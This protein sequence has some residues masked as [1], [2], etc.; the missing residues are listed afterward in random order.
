MKLYIILKY[1]LDENEMI[2]RDNE[3]ISI[4]SDIY[5][6]FFYYKKEYRLIGDSYNKYYIKIY[7]IETSSIIDAEDDS[8]Y[9]Q[10]Y[11]EF[12]ENYLD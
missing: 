7:D 2:E 11:D 8:F 1:S 9:N 4:F 6:S 5:E 10:C 12:I 3:F